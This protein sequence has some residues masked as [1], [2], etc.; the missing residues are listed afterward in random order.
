MEKLVIFG[1]SLFAEHVYFYIKYDSPYEAVAFTVDRKY[2]RKEE[3]LGL[4]VVPFETVETIFPPSE[5]KMLVSLGFQRLN[6]LRKER[7]VQAKI[8]GYDLISYVSSKAVTWP[9]FVM[10]D[11]CFVCEGIFSPH[12]QIGNDVIIGSGVVIGHHAVIKDHCFISPGVV[13]LGGVTVEECCLIGANATIKEGVTVA[14]ECIIGA[15]VAIM[16]STQERSVYVD[17]PAELLPKPSNILSPLLTWPV[18]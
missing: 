17:R 7:Y 12:V 18:K 8:K 10:G 2:I 5:C 6:K 13:M 4:P 11:N 9:G 3:L 15:G 16:R 1:N 14:K